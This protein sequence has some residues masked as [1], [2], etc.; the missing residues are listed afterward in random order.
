MEGRR[1]GV[2]DVPI[3]EE[4]QMTPR[5]IGAGAGS[6]RSGVLCAVAISAVAACRGG[7][8]TGQDAAAPGPAR[9]AAAGEVK[10]MPD[11]ELL[12]TL[13][14]IGR[15]LG[16]TQATVQDVA[17]VIGKTKEDPG[18]NMPLR[19]KPEDPSFGEAAVVRR[20]GSETPNH[21]E[22]MLAGRRK[23]SVSELQTALGGYTTPPRVHP[24]GPARII[25][26][27]P[28]SEA[29]TVIAEVNPGPG[30]VAD[31][32]VRSLTLRRDRD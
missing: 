4:D 24:G 5:A 8:A 30:G 22:L 7:A 16:A 26:G 2:E 9:G 25:F 13:E 1:Q 29:C 17:R 11:K 3:E 10:P 19:V 32:V 12:G 31:G 20:P 18:Q 27:K 21:V 23:V 14:K 6:R 28:I 15:A